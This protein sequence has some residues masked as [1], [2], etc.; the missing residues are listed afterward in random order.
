MVKRGLKERI[1]IPLVI[2][3]FILVAGMTTY[4]SIEFYRFT[5]FL[6]DSSIISISKSLINYQNEYRQNTK[7]AAISAAR[8]PDVIKAISER[9]TKLLENILTPMIELYDVTYFTV[10]DENG[11]VLLRTYDQNLYGDNVS[12]VQNIKDAMDGKIS[13][14]F[15]TGPVI[16]LSVHTGAPVYNTNGNI[17]GVISAG[18][19]FDENDYIDKLKDRFNAEFSIYLGDT[20]ITS[21]LMK[22]GK[23][24]IGTKQNYDFSKSAAKGEGY[25]D[26]QETMDISF[27]TFWLP[28]FDSNN[29]IFAAI[30]AGVSNKDIIEER[31][32]LI[33]SNIII[34][35]SG[36]IVSILI[37]LQFINRII[38]PVKNLIDLVSK[39][40]QGDLNICLDDKQLAE[41]EIDSLSF[42]VY[43]LIKVIKSMLNDLSR[44][45]MELN[46]TGEIDE[47]QIDTS[48]YSGSY[49]EIIE[50]INALCHSISLKNKTVA[51]MDFLDT[52]ISVVDFNYNILYLNKSMIDA[53]GIDK[54]ECNKKKCYKVIMKLDEP[55][56]YCKMKD[57]KKSKDPYPE[58]DYE[59]KFDV[60]LKKWISVRAVII[61]WVDGSRVYC[62]YVNDETQV[63][64][65]E[66]QLRIAAQKAHEASVAKSV[67]LA[68]MS[69]EIRTPMNSI[70]GFSELALDDVIP[71][72]TREYLDKILDNTKGLLQIINDILDIS[73]VESGKMEIENIPFD[74][75]ELFTNCKTIIMPKAAEKGISLYFY[76]DPIAGKMPLGDPTKLRQVFVNL[77]ANAVK[78]TNAG[79]VK[80]LAEVQDRTDDT[81]TIYFEVKDSG[82]GIMEEQMEFIFEP[83]VQGES[84]TTRQYGGSGLGLTITK[85]IIDLMGGK[86][87]VDSKVGIGSKFYFT[88]TF[89]TIDISGDKLYEQKMILSD[90]EKPTFEGEVLLCE[91]NA[92]NQQVICEHL[93]RVGLKTVVAWNGRIGFDL[94]KMRKLGGEKQFDLIFMD[95]HMPVMDGL[96]ATEKILELNTGIPIVAMTANIMADATETYKLTGLHDCVG[97]PF[98]SQEL[99]RCLLKFLTP[100]DREPKRTLETEEEF[101]RSLQ[102]LFVRSNQMIYEDIIKA[103]KDDDV[104]LAHRL[105]HSLKSNAAQIGKTELQKAAIEVETVFKKGDINVTDEQ[106]TALKNELDAVLAELAPVLQDEIKAGEE[107]DIL[108]IEL[109]ITVI[110]ELESC[111]KKGSPECINLIDRIRRL[112]GNKEIKTQIIQKI[113]DFDFDAALDF[114]NQLKRDININ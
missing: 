86:L 110:D 61:P 100:I 108:D 9:D 105:T 52:M 71:E 102:S 23:R 96:E 98:T 95:M 37:L 24:I 40:T 83:F 34:G 45:T 3:L 90:F 7:A 1:I 54:E 42:D 43:L 21:T 56:S 2:L 80:I 76:V 97:K 64:S 51:S 79:T 36:L 13:T 28:V 112:P 10:T 27:R 6:H 29:K 109:A 8:F 58:T 84:G 55:C 103:V 78:F 114:V 82:I 81:A 12:E 46:T 63:K 66:D 26:I 25:F 30:V 19:R 85:N 32:R 38:K 15:E 91:D 92:M 57:L 48:K 20:R 47:Y 68:N 72:R 33:I 17:T 5:S 75:H 93:E 65:F 59:Y 106:L 89:N 50:G 41:D 31:N 67:F 60:V 70:M 107:V 16:S 18:I 74:F 35:V 73:K 14:Y 11:N 88:L 111:L 101:Q 94:V 49:K 104:K 69:H 77:I 39:V 44:L 22:D 62:N 53:Y 113:E 87:S 99:W 4:S